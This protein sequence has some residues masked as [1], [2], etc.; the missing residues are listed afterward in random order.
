MSDHSRTDEQPEQTNTQAATLKYKGRQTPIVSAFGHNEQAE[1]II[2]LAKE[3][4]I[5]VY[6][7]ED[8]VNVL[9][10]L[11][12]G[13]AIPPELFEWVASVLAFAFFARNEV[14]EGFSPTETKTAYDKVRKAYTDI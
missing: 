7:D 2:K 10:Q 3:H 8:L 4:R 9:A 6:E 14:P 13:Q 11:D 5:P 1:A 12:V